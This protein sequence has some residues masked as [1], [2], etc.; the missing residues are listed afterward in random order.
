[1]KREFIVFLLSI[2]VMYSC[3]QF[4]EEDIKANTA[5]PI[6]AVSNFPLYHFVTSMVG[7]YSEVYYPFLEGDPAHWKL[8]PEIIAEYQKADIVFVNGANYEGW[9]ATASLRTSTV[10]NTTKGLKNN[11]IKREES[12]VHSHGPGGS[13]SHAGYYHTTWL[14]FKIANYQANHVKK[15]LVQRFPDEKESIEQAYAKLSKE[16]LSVDQYLDSLSDEMTDVILVVSS[17]EFH[18]LEKAYGF[19][20]EY[21]DWQPEKVPDEID[22]QRLSQ[23]FP[24]G[25]SILFHTEPGNKFKKKMNEMNIKIRE[26]WP[27]GN[28]L[29]G[30]DFRSMM[31]LN[32]I[33]LDALRSDIQF[34][35]RTR[36]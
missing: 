32:S 36:E 2:L 7:D 25:G 19:N 9:L 5:T 26:F 8:G 18:Y 24:D 33:T 29:P 23:I 12:M 16:L 35:Y 4:P 6:I 1:M 10:V 34:I 30:S 15:A 13:H 17:S 27:M 14:D 22:L 21:F 20:M 3:S 28:G 11:L 31:V